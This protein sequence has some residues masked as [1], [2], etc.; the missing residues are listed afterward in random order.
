[1]PKDK[2][3]RTTCKVA[4]NIHTLFE[5]SGMDRYFPEGVLETTAD[6]LVASSA[7]NAT[8]RTTD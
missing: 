4:M 3:I 8:G 2:P 7:A 5:K 1:M 6:L